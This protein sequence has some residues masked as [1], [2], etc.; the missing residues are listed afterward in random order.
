MQ[1]NNITAFALATPN[2]GDNNQI[3]GAFN[4]IKA[5]ANPSWDYAKSFLFANNEADISNVKEAFLYSDFENYESFKARVFELLEIFF[6]KNSN[7]PNIFITV[8]AQTESQ[9]A[10]ENV[11]M[12]CRA[13]KEY[14]CEHNLGPIVTSVLNSKYYRYKFVD[15][16]NIPKHLLTFSSRIRLIKDTSIASKSLV[17]TGTVHNFTKDMLMLEHEKLLNTLNNSFTKPQVVNQI[18]KI[19]KF[20]NTPKKVVFCLGGRVEGNEII[21]DISYAEKLFNDALMLDKLG[22]GV[23]FVNGPRTPNNVTDFLYQ[24]ALLHPRLTFQNSKI[25][26]QDNIDRDYKRWRIYSGNYE[27]EF[28]NLEE[29]GNIYPAI[30]GFPNTLVVHTLDTYACCETINA[31]IPTAIS[32]KGL[33]INPKIRYDC[34]NL[35]ELLCPKHAVDFDEFLINTTN[36]KVEPKDLKL[37]HL[38]NSSMVFAETLI[39]KII[40]IS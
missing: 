27:E 10:G 11:D 14:Y 22:Y 6:Q 5:I 9:A 32:T 35:Y 16:I 18:E 7:I 20:A 12:L 28:K 17:T 3:L 38:S 26:A 15:L 37:Q 39:N 23:I 30:L 13:I 4:A 19:K 31:L 25:I 29:I 1:R 24:K 21:F 8:S 40:E 34:L 36:F 33:Y 2:R